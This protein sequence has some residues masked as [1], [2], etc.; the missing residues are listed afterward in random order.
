MFKVIRFR[1]A[2][3]HKFADLLGLRERIRQNENAAHQA[4]APRLRQNHQAHLAHS[5]QQIAAL[6]AECQKEIAAL[7][8]EN[9]ALLLRILSVRAGGLGG[10]PAAAAT[11]TGG[12]AGD[13][14]WGHSAVPG[15][16]NLSL[17]DLTDSGCGAGPA[18]HVGRCGGG[19]GG[20]GG[21]GAIRPASPGPERRCGAA[22]WRS[23]G[24]RRRAP[25]PASARGRSLFTAPGAGGGLNWGG[26]SGGGGGGRAGARGRPHERGGPVPAAAGTRPPC[27]GCRR[28]KVAAAGDDGWRGGEGV[29]PKTRPPSRP[30]R[31]PQ[32][33]N[34]TTQV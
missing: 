9:S 13:G 10:R 26:G 11:T 16:Q 7:R 20:G 12:E 29:T 17:Q 34:V 2:L 30:L 18:A 32:P 21:G 14:L 5:Q 15:G 23:G 4:Q 22:R 28:A 33:A 31:V 19:G 8:A 24:T 25:A 6:L 1:N 27:G 3:I